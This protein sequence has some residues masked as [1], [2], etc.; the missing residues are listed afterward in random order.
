[1]LGRRSLHLLGAL[2]TTGDRCPASGEVA[3]AAG[4]DVLVDRQ[5]RTQR[6]GGDGAGSGDSRFR[7]AHACRR[8]SR[9]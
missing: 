6:Q 5:G 2:P 3:R 4:G 9:N 1:M 8:A 7:L